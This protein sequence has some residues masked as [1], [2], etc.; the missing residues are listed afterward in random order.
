MPERIYVLKDFPRKLKSEG[1]YKIISMLSQ[2]CLVAKK[3]CQQ[4]IT[5][6]SGRLE[7]HSISQIWTFNVLKRRSNAGALERGQERPQKAFQRWSI[8]T[9]SNE[10]KN[11]PKRRSNAGALERGQISYLSNFPNLPIFQPSNLP[12]FQPSQKTNSAL[13]KCRPSGIIGSPDSDPTSC[14][15]RLCA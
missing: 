1:F 14:A 9:R 13:K 7:K 2:V 8:G 11:V 3:A 4:P 12:L 5:V 6:F 15:W 10:V